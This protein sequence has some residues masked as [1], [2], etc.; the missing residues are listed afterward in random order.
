[1]LTLFNDIVFWW[2]LIEKAML[3]DANMN[4]HHLLSI[5][6][7]L[8]LLSLSLN[9]RTKGVSGFIEKGEI[10]NAVRVFR[11]SYCINNIYILHVYLK[12]DV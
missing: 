2:I 9:C 8:T 6:L 3:A 1:M 7:S 10:G 4:R 11:S 5:S 12:F